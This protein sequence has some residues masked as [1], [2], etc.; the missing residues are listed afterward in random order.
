MKKLIPTT[1][2]GIAGLAVVGL[3]GMQT[4]MVSAAEDE[5]VKREED[6]VEVVLVADDDSDDTNDNTNTVN[7]T[8]DFSWDG[9]SA[10]TRDHT[11]SNFTK[12]SRDRDVSR[13]DKTRDWTRDGGKKKRDFSANRTNDRSRN[14]T[15][16]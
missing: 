6:T 7:D 4:P 15:R 16:R 14:D 8:D 11:R 5:A 9:P 10:N 1:L 3:I 2:L 12:V 13:G